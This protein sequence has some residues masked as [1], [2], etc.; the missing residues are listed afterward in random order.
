M[1]TTI[2]AVTRNI[3]LVAAHENKVVAVLISDNSSSRR[4]S[5]AARIEFELKKLFWSESRTFT[6]EETRS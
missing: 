2:N 6:M 1:E 5:R 4:T 3:A